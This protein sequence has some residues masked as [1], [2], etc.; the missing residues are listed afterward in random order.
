MVR[1]HLPEIEGRRRVEQHKTG[2][3]GSEGEED[4]GGA[5]RGLKKQRAGER[6]GR[7]M[8]KEKVPRPWEG[9]AGK[10]KG[11]LDWSSPLKRAPL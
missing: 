1:W 2:A 9:G 10:A 3:G 11:R 6:N 8:E 5:G 7:G 4:R